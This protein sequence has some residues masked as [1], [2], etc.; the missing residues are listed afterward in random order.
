MSETGDSGKG[1]V[2]DF[3]ANGSGT[4][5]FRVLFSIALTGLLTVSGVFGNLFLAE[6]KS[7][8]SENATILEKVTHLSDTVITQATDIS[9]MQGRINDQGRQIAS[10]RQD[11]AVLKFKAG[12]K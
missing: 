5:T 12:I 3:I 4:V 10:N 7:L 8:Q 9:T 11:I 1:K 2:F 6:F